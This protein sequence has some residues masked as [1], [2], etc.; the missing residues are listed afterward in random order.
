M[1][2]R[3]RNQIALDRKD[4]FGLT[5]IVGE[6]ERPAERNLRGMQFLVAIERLPLMP[7]Q[8]RELLLQRGDL[9]D[10]CRRCHRAGQQPQSGTVILGPVRAALDHRS[11]KRFPRC[12]LALMQDRLRAVR[13]IEREDA[14]LHGR[15]RR[16]AARRVV[17]IS[18]DLHRPA[19]LMRHQH[20][21]GIA[22]LGQRGGIGARLAGHDAGRFFDIR[23]KLP[24]LLLRAAAGEPA[25]S[26]RCGHQL[27]E[28]PP[29]DHA[30]AAAGARDLALDLRRHFRH[31]GQFVERAPIGSGGWRGRPGHR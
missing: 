9:R 1:A 26:E 20:A 3:G 28:L 27:Q 5:Q 21:V 17:G 11:D 29:L 6:V 16:A 25:Q 12:D 2:G 31:F 24:R 14:R 4:N 30:E 23:Q 13:I 8:C 19:G 15:A 10:H 22:A 7:A 18:L